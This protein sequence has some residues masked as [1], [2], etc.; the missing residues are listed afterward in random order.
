MGDKNQPIT[1]EELLKWGEMEED[2]DKGW[3]L[4]KLPDKIQTAAENLHM[5]ADTANTLYGFSVAASDVAMAS[6][7]AIA[8]L[9]GFGVAFGTINYRKAKKAE[10]RANKKKKKAKAD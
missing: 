5:S 3:K 4:P 7:Q 1:N 8:P 2:P 9:A 10:V 6:T